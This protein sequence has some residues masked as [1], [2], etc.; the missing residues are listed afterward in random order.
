MVDRA[1]G[2]AGEEGDGED[3]SQADCYTSDLGYA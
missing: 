2:R 1:Y 3:S